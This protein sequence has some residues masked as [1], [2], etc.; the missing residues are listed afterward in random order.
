MTEWKNWYT[1][2]YQVTVGRRLDNKPRGSMNY[3]RK[4]AR[5]NHSTYASTWEARNRAHILIAWRSNALF[6]F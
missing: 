4:W 3:L 2:K 6:C 1:Y 5:V